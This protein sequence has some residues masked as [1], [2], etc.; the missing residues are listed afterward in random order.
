MERKRTNGHNAAQKRLD[1]ILHSLPG[2]LIVADAQERVIFINQAAEKLFGF[3][4]SEIGKK[5]VRSAIN[6]ET[7]DAQLDALAAGDA[8]LPAFDF[9]LDQKNR[10]LRAR[11]S[12][13]RSPGGRREGSVLMFHDVTREREL[14]LAKNEFIATA[15][16]ELRT[17]LTAIMGFAELL[18]QENEMGPFAPEQREEFI[19]HILDTGEALSLIVNDLLDLGRMESGG[20]MRL[21]KSTWDLGELM[22][23]AVAPF[24]RAGTRHHFDVIRPASEVLVCADRLR[25]LQVLDNLLTNAIKYSP[26]GGKIRVEVKDDDGKALVEVA[27]QGIG[28]TPEQLSR[29]FDKFYRADSSESAISGLGL[30]MSI[31]RG[32]IEAHQGRI[33][34][35]STPEK[36]TRVSFS[37]PSLRAEPISEAEQG[38]VMERAPVYAQP[39]DGVE[40]SYAARLEKLVHVG[41]EL[42]RARTLEHVMTIVRSAAR[43]LTGADGATFILR[44]NGFS[45]YADEDAVSPLFKGKKFPLTQCIGGWTILSRS[46]VA[47]ED[48][49][50]DTRI[51][52]G[53][54]TST[55]VKSL[56][57]VPVTPA[58][59]EDPL[60][61]IGTYWARI[62]AITGEEMKLLQMLADAVAAAMENIRAHE[63]RPRA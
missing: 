58:R 4:S 44:E 6:N 37:L 63:A 57:V 53:V 14:D 9:A 25:I 59:Q 45:Y 62:H 1:S 60:A 47:I 31:A 41:R 12:T 23:R 20:P 19:D 30:G 52:P 10:L 5:N 40:A 32:I 18:K 24:R 54:Y 7:V 13:L 36:G 55:F 8:P 21:E 17:P 48:I 39:A 33:W 42:S 27:D 3:S 28:M 61:A 22:E 43:E 51:P 46:P 11:F 2:A 15:A 38:R 34:A 16:H 35:Q 29:I 49:E 26:R 50:R 56:A